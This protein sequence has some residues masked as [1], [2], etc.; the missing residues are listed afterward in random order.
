MGHYASNYLTRND[1]LSKFKQTSNS[2]SLSSTQYEEYQYYQD[3]QY[4]YV[5]IAVQQVDSVAS[6]IYQNIMRDSFENE[7]ILDTRDTQHMTYHRD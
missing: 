5:F 3:D 7:W 4:E 1:Q 6:F 2:N